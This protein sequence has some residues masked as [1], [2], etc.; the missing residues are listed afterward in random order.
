MQNAQTAPSQT[1]IKTQEQADIKE[2]AS[3][4]TPPSR[5]KVESKYRMG[6]KTSDIIKIKKEDVYVDKS[7]S[8]GEIG[9]AKTTNRKAYGFIDE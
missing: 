3:K 2:Q 7:I 1:P 9:Q 4:I 6:N 8:S 5:T